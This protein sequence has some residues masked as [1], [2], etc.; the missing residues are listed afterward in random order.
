MR[1]ERGKEETRLWFG[2]AG[3]AEVQKLGKR[4][5]IRMSSHDLV[6]HDRTIMLT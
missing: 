2:A 5:K 3:E 1:R 4:V 6:T